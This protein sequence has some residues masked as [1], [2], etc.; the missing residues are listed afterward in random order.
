MGSELHPTVATLEA[1][2]AATETSPSAV[3]ADPETPEDLFAPKNKAIRPPT[4]RGEDSSKLGRSSNAPGDPTPGDLKTT[5]LRP[6]NA[7]TSVSS[8]PWIK[9]EPN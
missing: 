5:G 8:A 1:A 9:C 4:P 2:V 6:T 7:A 3:I